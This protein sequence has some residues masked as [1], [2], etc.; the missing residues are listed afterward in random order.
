MIVPLLLV[1]GLLCGVFAA[2]GLG[3]APGQR[4]FDEMA[5]MIPLGVGVLGGVL[6]LTAA[7]VWWR[8][9]Q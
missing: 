4:T 1:L 5:G 2:W 6:E 9:R 7:I 8:Q 3:T